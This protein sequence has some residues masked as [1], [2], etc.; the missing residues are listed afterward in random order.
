MEES[1]DIERFEQLQ[2][3]LVRELIEQIRLKLLQAGLSGDQLRETTGEIAFS[4]ASTIDDNSLIESDGLEA[5]PFLAFAD[6]R[7]RI[8][9][10]GEN[11]FMHEFV[12][13][14]MNQA[15]GK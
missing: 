14:V 12:A 6:G 1:V 3:V 10:C 4:V 13:S 11:S 5:H 9:H 15:F 2:Q 7:E 8:I